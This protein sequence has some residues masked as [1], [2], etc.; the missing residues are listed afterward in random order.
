[1]VR[2][3]GDFILENII[4]TGKDFSLIDWR[5]DFGGSLVGG[6][7]YYDLA[8][9]NHNLIF[10]HNLVNKGLFEIEVR[11]DRINCDIL[12][13][14]LMNECQTILHEFLLSKNLSQ[15]K[16]D[17]LTPIIWLN[18]S[19]LHEYPINTFLFYFGKYKLA[20]ALNL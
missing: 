14:S 18:M 3:H 12:T 10:N 16:V 5:Q 8:K 11:E 13:S 1:M 6:D 2:F 20:R 9:L 17:L 15:Y 7:V 4:D 19:P